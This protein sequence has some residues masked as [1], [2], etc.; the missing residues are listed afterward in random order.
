MVREVRHPAGD[1]GLSGHVAD[2]YDL[3]PDIDFSTRVEAALGRGGDRWQLRTDRGR[4]LSCRFYVMASGCLS[5]PKPPDIEGADRFDGDVYFT[6]SWPH[7]GV[8]FTGKR[9]AVIGTGSSGI[10]AI[11]LIAAQATQLTVFQ[12]TPNFSIPAHNGPPPAERLAA[13]DRPG[14]LSRGGP[15]VARR[16]AREP[17]DIS[18]VTATDEV[19]RGRFE[20]AWESG[21]L[22][23]ILGVFN[24]QLFN[25][26]SN[27][28]VAEMIREKIRTVVMDPRRPRPFAPGTT[29]L[30]PNGRVWIPTTSRPS[31]CPMSG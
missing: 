14:G 19:R 20:S 3:R 10:Q 26:A 11:P 4:R 30:G 21:E 18:G 16:G 25:P 7:E 23:R 24:D 12:R 8:D 17:T 28:I 2:R 6:S 22:F 1:P 9:V 27:E 13:L 31:I 5:V 29:P 15:V